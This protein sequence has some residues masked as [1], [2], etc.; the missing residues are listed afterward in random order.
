METKLEFGNEEHIR[1]L[2]KKELDNI[3]KIHQARERV[4]K[5]LK[6]FFNWPGRTTKEMVISSME[7]YIDNYG[8]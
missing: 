1:L 8:S 2:K 6:G 3:Q 7:E 5:T 4:R